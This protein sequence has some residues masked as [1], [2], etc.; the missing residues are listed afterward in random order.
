MVD[1]ICISS[2]SVPLAFSPQP[3]VLCWKATLGSA[4]QD[5][6]S[7]PTGSHWSYNC[8]SYNPLS[9]STHVFVFCFYIGW[10]YCTVHGVSPWTDRRRRRTAPGWSACW[11]RPRSLGGSSVSPEKSFFWNNKNKRVIMIPLGVTVLHKVD[12]AQKENE[13]RR[14][15]F[16]LDNNHNKLDKLFYY[17]TTITRI[18]T[19]LSLLLFLALLKTSLLQLW[20]T[21]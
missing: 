20:Q 9:I 18:L 17:L 4:R 14:H 3:S 21:S 10:M 13:T 5:M 2:Q 16:T 15:W 12:K 7:V 19:I 1:R 6:W 11:W 8:H